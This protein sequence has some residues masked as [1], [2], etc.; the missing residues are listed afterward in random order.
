[1]FLTRKIGSLLRGKATAPQILMAAV[2]G[3]MLGFVP[4]FILP[5]D[6]GGGFLQAPGLILTFFVLV[7]VLNANLG[8]FG[9]VTL[10]AK[11][12]S[13]LALPLSYRVGGF[14]L[15]GPTQGLFKSLINGKVTAWFGFERY[16]TTGGLV[17]GLVFGA[18]VGIL[19]VKSIAGFRKKMA[20][21]EAGSETYKKYSSKG[22]VR[23]LTWV[24]FGSGLGKKS[25]YKELAEQ[26]RFGSPVRLMGVVF[27]ALLVA[28]LW[29][30]KQWFS[31]KYLTSTVQGGLETANGSTVDLKQAE[32][33]FAAGTMT[34]QG[35]AV[36]DPKALDKNIFSADKL[37]AA[38]DTGELLRKRIVIDRVVSKD[39]SSGLGRTAP[40][41]PVPGKAPP[42]PPP[43]PPAGTKTIDDYLKDAKVWKERLAQAKDWLDTIHGGGKGAEPESKEQ[44][45]EREAKEASEFGYAQVVAKH[46]LEGAP[47]LLVRKISFEGLKLADLAGDTVDVIGSDFSTDPVLAG[48]SPK[49]TVKSSKTDMLRFAMALG[50]AKGAIQPVLDI[51]MKGL[52][53]DYLGNQLAKVTGS[54]PLEGG[55]FDFA[56]S[57]ASI[58]P[59][60]DG[61]QLDLPLAVTLH[62]TTLALQGVQKTKLD[63][64][65]LPIGIRGSLLSPG[66]TFD[67]KAL[68]QAL[69]A[70]GK[71]ELVNQVKGRADALLKGK[72][73]G[74]GEALGGVLGGTKTPEQIA[75]EAKKKAEEEA[76]KKLEAELK[77]R[78]PG[79]L[80]NPFGGKK[81]K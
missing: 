36:S 7:A 34:L 67:D 4:G 19:L 24:F 20:A 5:G 15:D 59:G 75:D 78:L 6:L 10:A 37:E 69:L 54:A 47:A 33:D 17:V 62:G 12:L 49:L 55:T 77:K 71:Q 50:D 53:A 79:G 32:L 1:M 14:L 72:L 61:W 76:K 40:G 66:I 38:I 30:G 56:S 58:T 8:V 25:S 29:A 13:F 18:L 46:L 35:L 11:L 28:T 31:A 44:R 70:A 74:A 45:K 65:T 68:E 63:T 48:A 41:K 26:K 16:A 21:L 81:D 57:K 22:S 80:P 60:K 3:G 64:L 52:P 51:A 9:L 27:V 2:L 73:P 43:P 23:F 39:A 42:P